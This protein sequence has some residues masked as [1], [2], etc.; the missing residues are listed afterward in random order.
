MYL[1]NPKVPSGFIATVS[2]KINKNWF[3]SENKKKTVRKSNIYNYPNVTILWTEIG[4]QLLQLC[5]S[6]DVLVTGIFTFITR[7]TGVHISQTQKCY[8]NSS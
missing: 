5:G 4:R 2:I 6:W 1:N 8:P 3:S 7:L